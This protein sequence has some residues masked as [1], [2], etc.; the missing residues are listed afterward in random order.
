MASAPYS[1]CSII[2]TFKVNDWDKVTP[3]LDELVEATK[4]ETG[5]LFYGFVANKESNTL[6]CRESYLDG[7]AVNKHLDNVKIPLGKLLDGPAELVSMHVQGPEE[8]LAKVKPGLD[9][10]G[11]TYTYLHPSGF[12]NMVTAAEDLPHTFCTIYPTFTVVDW[13]KVEEEVIP[14]LIE[15]TKSEKGCVYYGFTLNKEDNKL[16]CHEAYAD[17][18]A[19]NTHLANALPILGPA[20]DGGL[21]KMESLIMTGP[22][23]QLKLA[24]ESGDALGAV[25]QETIPDGFSRVAT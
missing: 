21:M 2:P 25:Y 11:A 3:I 17:G 16:I 1:F 20:L 5:V 8:E 4:K 7:N 19:L 23:D 15:A 10:L 9:P 24:K 22:A 12:T 14:V 18:D 6:V 13:P